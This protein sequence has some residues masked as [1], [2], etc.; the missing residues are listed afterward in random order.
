LTAVPFFCAPNPGY[1]GAVKKPGKSGQRGDK[2]IEDRLLSQ[3]VGFR[4]ICPIC[5]ICWKRPC[6]GK[7][8][9]YHFVVSDD[10]ALCEKILINIFLIYNKNQKKIKKPS[11]DTGGR[12]LVCLICYRRKPS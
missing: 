11:S 9:L 6:K 10:T 12:F 7:R 1:E 5:L 8:Q 2:G 3:K 4:I